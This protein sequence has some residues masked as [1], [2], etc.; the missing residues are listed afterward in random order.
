MALAEQAR[1]RRYGRSYHLVI[2]N[3]EDLECL[4]DLDEAHWTAT[5]APIGALKCDQAFLAF[6][7]ADANGRITCGEVKDAIRWLLRNLRDRSGVAQCREAAPLQALNT[8]EDEGQRIHVAATKMLAH[9]DMPDA[10]EITLEQVRQIK[11]QTEGRPVSDKGVVLTDAAQDDDV[12]QFMADI[13]AT[14]GGT[15]HP[16]GAQGVGREQLDAFLASA[17]A[18]LDWAGRGEIPEG[19]T[20]SEIM[21]LGTDTP[22]AAALVAA[23]RGKIDQFFAQC[24]AVALDHRLADEISMSESEL[25]GVNLSDPAAIQEM[26]KNAPLAKPS[27]EFVLRL[28]KSVN[29]HYAMQIDQLRAR[30]LQPLLGTETAELSEEQW[31]QVT[32]TFAPHEAW[33]SSKP[34]P[35]VDKLGR[36]KLRNYL[37]E[38]FRAA[39]EALVAESAAT[40]L[41]LENVRLT[42]KLILYQ[43]LLVPLAN[44]FASF[45]DLYAADRRAMFEMGTLVMDGR[46][47]N[48]CVKVDNRS[49][50]SALAKTSSMFLLYV[51]ITS[52]QDAQDKF[53]LAT[54]VTWGDKGNLVV[55]KRGVFVDIDGRLWDA[56]AVQII[57]N[58]ISFREALVSPFQRLGSLLTGKIEGMTAEAEKKLDATTASAVKEV[59]TVPATPAPAPASA[60]PTRAGAAGILLGGGVA[61]AAL[62]SSVA[63]VTKTFAAMK[64]YAILAGLGGAVLAVML[65]ISIVAIVKLRRRDLSPMLEGAGWAINTRM[66]VT[67]DQARAFTQRPKY[68]HGAQ[69]IART[70]WWVVV[71]GVVLAVG[72]VV[73]VYMCQPR[74][75][76]LRA[77]KSSSAS[78]PQAQPK[79]KA[80]P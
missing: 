23:L 72:M 78:A 52:K 41:A 15:P 53:E 56:K 80:K 30:V 22:E 21:P 54:P 35:Q 55:G 8:D 10:Q 47:F 67:S 63:F 3:A 40:A 20:H 73:A 51:E 5:S 42:E 49:D 77:A 59:A 50:H 28:D 27:C 71:L 48:L 38:R 29:P 19:Q 32:A 46:R 7:D 4:V 65:P 14:V 45:P 57:E 18:Y 61:V 12:R 17:Q 60:P 68:P 79:A 11:A 62:G 1:F 6:V 66:Q 24:K 13:M 69:G 39:V 58:P 37:H 34:G 16:S 33:A 74:V 31:R 43:A 44:N 64:W 25:Q 76:G 26:L 70:R 2:E 75:S 36:D 9:L